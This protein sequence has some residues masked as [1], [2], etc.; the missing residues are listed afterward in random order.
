MVV[1]L[2][3]VFDFLFWGQGL[4]SNFAIFTSL[5]TA[6]GVLL[7][8]SNGIKPARP[9]LG[10]GAVWLFFNGMT[11]MRQ[12]TMS[13]FLAVTFTL[14]PM[15]VLAVTYSRG[16]WI[17]YSLLDYFNQL[18]RLIESTL[19][20]PILFIS[21]VRKERVKPAA[22]GRKAPYIRNLL[23]LVIAAPIVACFGGLLAMADPIFSQTLGDFL[24]VFNIDKAGEYF[25]RLMWIGMTAYVLA[26]VYLHA[27][28][29][30]QGEKLLGQEKPVIPAFMG[31][32]EIAI[33]LG[34]VTL[35][36]LLFVVI[37]FQ[38]FFGG[39]AN[40]SLS[41]FTY[42]EYARRGFNELM[43][44]AFFSLLMILGL[45]TITR[46]ESGRQKAI[47]SGLNITILAEVMVI[48]VSAYQRLS[49][50]IDYFG[51]SRFRL[52]PRTFMI[53]VGIL[54]AVVVVLEVVRRERFFALA[55]AL[56]AMGFAASICL[57]NV[58]DAIV[59]TNVLR[60]GE[61]RALDVPYLASLSLDGVPALAEAFQNPSLGVKVHEGIGAAL[62]C[63][64]NLL[65]QAQS[66]GDLRSTNIS[67][68]RAGTALDGVKG[69]LAQYK[70]VGDR[71]LTVLTPGG[72]SY[73]CDS[74]A[75]PNRD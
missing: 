55:M 3:F 67:T 56:A 44:V 58:D 61:G 70:M 33:V 65:G 37:Q 64:T 53:W 41:G 24:K 39:H 75:E 57:V 22:A 6:G 23:G 59:R 31:F 72:E 7:L 71:S 26:G 17:R 48:L 36:F 52:Y 42:S 34:C 51:F 1:A 15:G 74:S 16:Q 54:L 4:G 63:H 13:V 60:A 2:G 29:K 45:S 69:G 73:G 12:E 25:F 66:K 62:V 8:I 27:G 43:L 11:L 47:F 28:Q 18:L 9:A 20:A 46:R 10:L 14:F 19:A 35:L 50:T 38:Y 5:A 21:Q 49:L 68:W 30:S 32:L 40:I